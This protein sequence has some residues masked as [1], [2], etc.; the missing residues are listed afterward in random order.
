MIVRQGIVTFAAAVLLAAP[1][2]AQTPARTVATDRP[3][4]GVTE[5]EVTLGSGEWAVTGVLTLPAGDGPHPAAVLMHGSGPG[6]RDLDVGPNKVFREE[7]WGL[8]ARG[9]AVLRYDKRSTAHAARYRALGRAPTLDEEFTEEGVSA[10][11][12][13]RATP[14][15]D[16]RRV[17]LVGHSQ[18]TTFTAK[19]ANLTGAAGVVQ[20]AAS[21]RPAHVVI[22]EQVEYSLSL[23]ETDSAT[24]EQARYMLAGV[25]RMADPAT[26]DTAVV[27]GFPMPYWRDTGPEFGMREME[28]MLARGGRAL[29]VQGG[30][31]YLVTDADFAIWRERFE[32]RPGIT[33]RRYA[34]LNHLM[35]PG[36]G[37]MKPAEYN[38]RREV[39]RQLLE[40][41]AEW[42]R[43]R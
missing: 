18:S 41:V 19:V 26:P 32:G 27:L 16:P 25:A 34:D 24:R 37:R 31:D 40:D 12:L 17:Y 13:L 14:G 3:P 28:T 6:T 7:A 9:V 15:V 35:Q 23:P 1:S 4:S 20:L 21:A 38:E 5:R 29:V 22:R 43:E 42:I 10:V 30:R 39:S 11:R 2:A 33:L 36:V 8:A